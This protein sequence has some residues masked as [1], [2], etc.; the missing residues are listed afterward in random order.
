MNS[1]IVTAIVAGVVAIAGLIFRKKTKSKTTKRKTKT[2]VTE[3][4]QPKKDS[5]TV[6]Q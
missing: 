3:D 5:T 2:V 6:T 4:D 1:E